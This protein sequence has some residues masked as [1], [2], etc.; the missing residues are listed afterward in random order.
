[1]NAP[2]GKCDECQLGIICRDCVPAGDERP[3]AVANLRRY[4]RENEIPE[5]AV[6]E[7]I[8]EC[9]HLEGLDYWLN[10]PNPNEAVIADFKMYREAAAE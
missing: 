9:E 6:V 8:G 2:C 3:E 1:M 10:F 5:E 7:Y 4:A